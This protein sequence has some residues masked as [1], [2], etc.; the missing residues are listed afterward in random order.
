MHKHYN[1]SGFSLLPVLL[2]VCLLASTVLA[3][4]GVKQNSQSKTQFTTVAT[5]S[6]PTIQTTS[7]LSSADKTT[8]T[9]NLSMIVAQLEVYFA[10]NGGYYPSSISPQEFAPS[11]T[12]AQ[13]SGD[14]P[15]ATVQKATTTPVGVTY[16][17]TATP[18]GCTTA[19]H[20]CQHY[21]LTATDSTGNLVSEKKD[22]NS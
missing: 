5:N 18:D 8:A 22:L 13:S 7:N 20:N 2:I 4:Y 11:A 1:A 21:S 19:A 14:D 6:K 10:A 12:N 3:V 9:T 17:Y 16:K 15:V